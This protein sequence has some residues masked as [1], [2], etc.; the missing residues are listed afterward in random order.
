MISLVPPTAAQVEA[1]RR[2]R[3]EVA[4]TGPPVGEVP[5]GYHH[6][7]FE[8]SLG[9]RAGAFER[10]RLG[11]EGWVPQ[12]GSG[13]EV[14][15][16]AGAPA[17]GETVAIVTRQLGLWVLAACRVVEVVDEPDRF[18]FTYATLPDHPEEGWESFTVA[19]DEGEVRFEIAAASRPAAALVRLGAPVG[20]HLQRRA[21]AG[22][23]DALA[24]FVAQG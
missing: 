21:A 24:R 2:A 18:G 12:R 14:R 22:Y 6:E 9:G 4:T 23:L 10:A 11:I 20:R 15:S 16:P 7:R 1:H 8:R 3:I 19:V 13:V 17:V 5:P